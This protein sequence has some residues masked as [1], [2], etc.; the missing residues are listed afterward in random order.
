[1]S[2]SPNENTSIAKCIDADQ[3]TFPDER[4][5]DVDDS[6]RGVRCMSELGQTRP[7]LCGPKST[8]DRCSPKADKIS[9]PSGVQGKP[10][11]PDHDAPT[12]V[13]GNCLVVVSLAPM[14][15][16]FLSLIIVV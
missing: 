9:K 11:L 16:Q 14:G 7:S 8:N 13:A 3:P 2:V 4:G 1:M 5:N 12:R 6:R 10:V 15:G